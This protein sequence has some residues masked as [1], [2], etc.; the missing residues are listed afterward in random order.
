ML[1]HLITK[2]DHRDRQTERQTD[3]DRQIQTASQLT[4]TLNYVPGGFASSCT[5]V[6][7]IKWTVM[8]ATGGRY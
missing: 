7:A 2:T 5:M 8:A 3:R 6:T 4:L 1:L